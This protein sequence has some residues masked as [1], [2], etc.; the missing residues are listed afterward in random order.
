M[1]QIPELIVKQDNVE[2]IRDVIASILIDEIENQKALAASAGEDPREWDLRIYLERNNPVSDFLDPK[3]DQK[4][5]P[6]VV[7]IQLDSWSMDAS[8]SN[9][10]ERQGV[11]AVYH[12]DCY[13]YGVSSDEGPNQG[14]DPGDAR[15]ALE[16]QRAVRLVRNILMSSF[17]TYLGLPQGGMQ[18]VWRRWVDSVNVFQPQLDN[19]AVNQVMAARMQFNVEF[20]EFSPQYQAMLLELVSVT[21]KRSETGDDY[22]TA[23]YDYT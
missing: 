13:G 4:D 3:P 11:T 20:S 19:R 6:P 7:N 23:T 12:I 2:L 5:N 15:S 10:V 14:H 1:A 21:V 18:S 16:A 8:K 17:Y 22:L 9:Q